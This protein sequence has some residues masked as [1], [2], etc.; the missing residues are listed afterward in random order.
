MGSQ[1]MTENSAVPLFSVQ[2]QGKWGF[3]DRRAEMVIQPQYDSVLDFSE[4]LAVA[5]IDGTDVYIDQTGEVVMRPPFDRLSRFSEGLACVGK[6]VKEG[7]LTTNK[8]GFIDKHGDLV[9]DVKFDRAND[10]SEGLAAAS[11]DGYSYGFIDKSGEFVIPESYRFAISFSEGLAA[12]SSCYIDKE[13]KRPFGDDHFFES[14]KSFQNGMAAVKEDGR[15]GFINRDNGEIVIEPVWDA[16]GYFS[17]EGLANVKKDRRW[18]FIDRTG[19]V[20]IEPQFSTAS[21][22]SHGMAYVITTSDK[23]CYIGPTGEY[24]WKP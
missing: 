10:F 22:F 11:N 15:W 18:G 2:V 13:G 6:R 20:V 21:A 12:V 9:I 3:I 17:D 16:A 8:W 24:I 7:P 23:V 19:S 1:E 4:G 5:G 14:V